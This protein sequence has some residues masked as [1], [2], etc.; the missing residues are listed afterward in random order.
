MTLKFNN[1]LTGHIDEFVS[2]KDGKVS[3]YTCG[4]T[5]YNYP[6]IGNWAAYIY[7][8]ILVRILMANSYDVNRVMNI[9]DVGHLVSDADEGEDKLEVGA[10]REGKTAWE[11]AEFY[12]ADFLSGMKKLNLIIPQHVT[13]ATEYIPQQLD[14]I[15]QLKEKSFTYQ[16]SDGIYYDTSKFIQYADFAHLDL[17][18]QKSGTRVEVSSE[19]RN[20]SDFAL[21]KFT[22]TGEKRDMQWSTPADLLEDGSWN[23]EDGEPQDSNS[24]IP[25][26]NSQRMGFPGW[27]LECSAMAMSLLGNTI[28]IHTGGIDAIP[29]HHTNEIAQSEAVT[30]VRFANYWLH[31][32]FLKVN[33]TKISKSLGNVY[34][35]SD[36]IEKGFNPIDFRM[37][38]LQGNYRN[39]GNFTFD[40]L[41]AAKN[42]LNNWKNTAAIRHQINSTDGNKS[43]APFAVSQAII[44]AVNDDLGTPAALKIVDEAFSQIAAAKLADINRGSLIQMLETIDSVLGLQIIDSTPDIGDEA[45]QIIMQRRQARDQKDWAVS[46]KLRDQLLQ[47]H[48]V[49]RDTADDSIW[50]YEL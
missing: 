9:T 40:N 32:N 16:T 37:F 22:P 29:V 18:A 44:E 20:P 8:D 26:A 33:G 19:K 50:E 41:T 1:T 46:D 13:K 49:I 25:I 12:T 5:V 6:H 15:R 30:G 4:P 48:I 34:L 10:K 2:L 42:R 11:I 31:N 27:H 45:K 36:L 43:V 14:L 3:L 39:E 28:D 24:Q 7:W 17:T 47:M 38:I 23:M 35:L 21:W